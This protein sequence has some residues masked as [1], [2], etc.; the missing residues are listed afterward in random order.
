MTVPWQ[1]GNQADGNATV[2]AQ[3]GTLHGNAYVYQTAPT[4]TPEEQF[5]VAVNYLQGGSP[6]EA[7]RRIH[8]V[9]YA[10]RLSSAEVAYFWALS[11]LSGRSLAGLGDQD[12]EQLEQ[13]FAMAGQHASGRWWRGSATLR[14]LVSALL[15][16]GPEPL[17]HA[18][19]QYSE[20]EYALRQ[21]IERHLS[22]I[23]SGVAQDYIESLNAQ[24]IRIDRVGDDRTVRVPKFFEADPAEPVAKV[25]RPASVDATW[26]P[27]LGGGALAL[28][29]AVVL[30]SGVGASSSVAA[31]VVFLL[32]AGGA[33]AVIRRGSERALL[34]RWRAAREAEF[35]AGTR[36]PFSG[37]GGDSLPRTFSKTIDEYVARAFAEQQ[38]TDQPARD[39]FWRDTYG[40]RTALH[41]DLVDLYGLR[42]VRAEAVRWLV[43]HHAERI[44]RKW[45]A[46]TLDDFRR[47]YSPAAFPPAFLGGLAALALAGLI[48]LLTFSA[49]TACLLVVAAPMLFFGGRFAQ[50]GSL[51]LY[52]ERRRIAVDN[53]EFAERWNAEIEAHG[54]WTA[55]LADRPTDV[56]MGRWLSLDL[57]FFKREV[58]GD[59]RLTNRDL[60]THLSLTEAA[61]GS[62]RARDVGG[63]FRHS[64]YTVLL[65]L[66]TEGG[67]RQVRV[68]LDTATG[69]FSAERRTT[70]RYD[71]IGSVQVSEV[72]LRQDDGHLGQKIV[73]RQVFLLALV[74]GQSIQVKLDDFAD[75][76]IACLWENPERLAELALDASGVTSA[77]RV[78]EAIA[79]DGRDWIA[80][81]RQRLRR[82][83]P[84]SR[85][86]TISQRGLD[87]AP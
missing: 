77:L 42:G 71:A 29:G 21:D 31:V 26:L 40:L 34:N 79:A 39:E 60:L 62:E 13:A 17:D 67:V 48:V 20:L 5:Q 68:R 69:N 3:I 63:P 30:A 44:G 6:G 87:S 73:T 14:T 65:F 12:L 46:G 35:T 8:E 7:R 64:A 61:P 16:N 56:E 74:N 11:V 76:S 59:Y 51:T 83:I 37:P 23:L 25:A 75:E 72:G 49:T 1:Q 22:L 58:M 82:R 10:H 85:V 52:G 55:W 32:L 86:G 43:F 41:A 24:Q 18:L 47:R 50:Q 38:P 78:L 80:L 4:A 9:V 15:G 45:Q 81:E 2:G 36:A 33:Y 57:A 53:A 70:F 28:L 66:L 19:R 84:S 27:L 54:R